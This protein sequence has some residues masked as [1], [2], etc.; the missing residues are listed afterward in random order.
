MKL[1]RT[2]IAILT[3]S[4]LF[5]A[6]C[7]PNQENSSTSATGA[8]G[9]TDM[10]TVENCGHTI[11]LRA[12]AQRIVTTEQGA[13]E[14]I[15]SLGG[16]DEIVGVGHTKDA[17]WERNAKLAK[18]LPI[19]SDTIP[20][21]EEVRNVDADLVVSPF[22][23]VF[24]ADTVGTREEYAKLGVGT[25]VTNLECAPDNEDAFIT[26]ERDY[27]Q[28]GKLL[29]REE[30][31][32]KLIAEQRETIASAK[33]SGTGQS[34][35][36][37]YSV[38]DDAPY[39][40]GGFALTDA[41]AKITNT[42]NSFSNLK[43]DWPQIS[44]ESFADADPDII[45]LVDLPTRGKPGDTAAEKM[46]MLKNNPATRNMRAVRENKFIAVPG[47]GLS[48]SARAVEPLQVIGSELGKL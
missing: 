16:H 9:A 7:S 11:E 29:G 44:W 8:S 15:L 43:E 22:A 45:F 32:S 12:P 38:F 18:D 37:L 28:L 10:I 48:P 19:L 34:T 47:V 21:T 20:T 25:W 2:A 39:V 30:E 42:T 6:A 3:A 23:S 35:V 33:S 36:Y 41:I 4:T 26:L 17:Y 1:S 46:E 13:T 14:T 24:T 31:A 27:E 40:A 5:L